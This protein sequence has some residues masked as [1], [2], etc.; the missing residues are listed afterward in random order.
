SATDLF[1]T[2]IFPSREIAAPY[3]MTTFHTRDG[4]AITG[5]IAFESADGVIVRTSA[6]STVRL[7]GA[8]I[9]ARQ[10]SPLSL[11]PSKL[12]AGLPPQGVAD[13]YAYLKWVPQRR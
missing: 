8:D 2:I 9:V 5:L 11:M 13:L 10:A 12:L 6:T 4:Q 7:A 1:D 3:R